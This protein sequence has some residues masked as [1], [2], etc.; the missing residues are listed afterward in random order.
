M[1]IFKTILGSLIIVG[2][3]FSS[4]YGIEKLG[5]TVNMSSEHDKLMFFEF[6]RFDHGIPGYSHVPS[7]QYGGGINP[8]ATLTSMGRSPGKYG[9]RIHNAN[10]SEDDYDFRK[11]FFI[12]SG[13]KEIN[14][15]LD[16]TGTEQI[17]FECDCTIKETLN[18]KYNCIIYEFLPN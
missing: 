16:P 8:K 6:V 2:L 15:K 12:R 7:V 13:V 5:T 1:S 3:L 4:L 17:K 14:I 10:P 11:V 18:K 9:I